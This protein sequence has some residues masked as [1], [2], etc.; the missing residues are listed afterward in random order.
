MGLAGERPGRILR[1]LFRVPLY[2]QRIGL[3]GW[4]RLFG[5]RFM[6]ITTKG[7]RTGKPH[8]VLIDILEHDPTKDVYYVQSAYG[9]R[10]DWVRNIK[11]NPLFEAEVGRNKFK[12]RA[13][14]VS[15]Q[16]T[17]N[18]LINYIKNHKK[19]TKIMMNSIGVDLDEY[20]EDE[21]RVKLMDEIVLEIKPE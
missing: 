19:Y 5:I 18:L 7:R 2:L 4:E 1:W 9:D 15:A 20:S 3:G 13:Q 17:S 21:L 16:K 10:A 11:T 12:A 14:C 6:K 8:S